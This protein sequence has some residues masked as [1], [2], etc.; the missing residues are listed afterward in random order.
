MPRFKHHADS[1]A[2][3]AYPTEEEIRMYELTRSNEKLVQENTALKESQSKL[4]S[5]L[6]DKKLLTEK[7]VSSLAIN[8]SEVTT[9]E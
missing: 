2:F 5:M 8:G 6:V 7:E 9:D 3:E 1:G 4:L